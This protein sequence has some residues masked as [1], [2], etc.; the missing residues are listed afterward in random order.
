MLMLKPGVHTRDLVPELLHRLVLPENAA[1]IGLKVHRLTVKDHD[2]LYPHSIGQPW[3]DR[4]IDHI[5]SANCI[6]ISVPY[7]EWKA[8]RELALQIRNEY[9]VSGSDNLIHA[10]DSYEN[11]VRETEYFFGGTKYAG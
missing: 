6:L 2:F 1:V 5:L 8:Y 7:T 9:G 11:S 3:R 4:N 10:S